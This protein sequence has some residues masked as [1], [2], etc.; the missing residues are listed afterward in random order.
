MKKV[1]PRHL[2]VSLALLL[3]LL[4][5]QSSVTACGPFAREAI[6]TYT[7]HPDFPLES[8]ARG[9][10]GLLQ[11]TYARSYLFVAY[12]YLNGTSLNSSEQQALLSLWRDRI[13]FDWEN[14]A[15]ASRETWLAARKKVQGASADVKI[16]VYR[17]KKQGEYDFFLNC[18]ADAFE[19]AARTLDAR[20]KQFGPGGA[21]VRDWLQAQD[22]VF[23]NCSEGET[24]PDAATSGSPIVRADRDYQRAAA[25]FYA[26]KYDEARVSF[27]K[28]ASDASSPWRETAQYMVARSLIRKASVGDQSGRTEALT[29]AEQQLKRTLE[30]SKQGPLHDSARNLMSLVRMRLRPEERRREL[31]HSLTSPKANE[32]LKQELWDYTILLDGVLGESSGPLTENETSAIPSFDDDLSDWLTNF[33]T[34][35]KAAFN[36][37]LERW[38]ANASAAWLVA[39]LSKAEASHEAVP[40][41][42]EAARKLQPGHAAYA[43]ASYHM[44]RLL[45]GSGDHAAARTALDRILTETQAKLPRSAINDFLHQRMLLASSLED[46]LKYA[47]RLPAAFSWGEDARELPIEPKELAS[48]DELKALVGRTLFDMDAARIMNVQLPLQLLQEAAG[49]RA[50]P[51]HLRRRVALAA[52]T[53]AAMLDEFESGRALAQMLSTLAPEMKASLAS[54]LSARTPADRRA[55]ALYTLLKFPGTRPFIDAGVGRFTPLNQRDTYRDNWWCA[56][57]D[58][59]RTEN[60]AESDA[61]ANTGGGNNEA[62]ALSFLNAAQRAAAKDEGARLASFGA[63]PNYLARETIAWAKAAPNDARVPE[64][65]HIAVM[66]TRYGCTN[67][68]TGEFSKQAWQ[69]L[70]TRYKGS[71][72]ARR[73]PYWFKNG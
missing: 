49:S 64:A 8:F 18:P 12:R 50:L 68:E 29:Q 21:E 25:L 72:W 2:A 51:D 3:S 44:V 9:E 69:I 20:I 66:A 26:M 73:T 16:E 34:I 24:F 38:R 39:S 35:G 56:P 30:S 10:L 57:A 6:F 59:Y 23:A 48:D 19:T 52:W 28:I 31:A 71:V 7:K 17:D 58:I 61:G 43:T 14:K 37:A 67:A 40:A 13:A 63:A 32:N 53:R 15:E 11:P 55:A 33:Q 36:H 46:F 22:K 62:P 65:L 27:E 54:Y 1:S 41:L 47:Q 4:S 60:S 42:I 45:M 5:G 70:H